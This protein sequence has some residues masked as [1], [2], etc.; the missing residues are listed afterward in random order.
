MECKFF[1]ECGKINTE[2]LEKKCGV[3]REEMW[4]VEQ[5]VWSEEKKVWSVKV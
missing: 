2:C 4:S 5:E 1:F 3:W